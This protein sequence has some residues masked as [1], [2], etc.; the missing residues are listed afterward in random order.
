M[1]S[2]RAIQELIGERDRLRQQADLIDRFLQGVSDLRDDQLETQPEQ[3]SPS[4]PPMDLNGSF[5]ANVRYALAQIG[6]QATS[7]HVA[8]RMMRAGMSPQKNGKPLRNRVAVELFR[9]AKNGTGGV[10]KVARG[11]YRIDVTEQ[12]SRDD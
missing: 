7:R 12:P 4:N 10:R 8:L 11:R 1:I 9:M 6:Q 5:A 2:A 3:A